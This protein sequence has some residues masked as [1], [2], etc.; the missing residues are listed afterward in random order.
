M[1]DATTDPARALALAL[2]EGL[3]RL[4]PPNAYVPGWLPVLFAGR[5]TG[6]VVAEHYAAAACGPIVAGLAAALAAAQRDLLGPL[7][8]HAEDAR[9]TFAC[10]LGALEARAECAAELAALTGLPA[11]GA[12]PWAA[13]VGSLGAILLVTREQVCAL[14]PG[15]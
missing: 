3:V 2:A 14:P 5:D 15:G 9:G 6:V 8:D 13:L 12:D 1:T 4:G 10:R 7:A 11:R